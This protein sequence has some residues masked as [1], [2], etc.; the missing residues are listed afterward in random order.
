MAVGVVSLSLARKAGGERPMLELQ[1]QG[2]EV[3]AAGSKDPAVIDGRRVV[4]VAGSEEI[5]TLHAVMGTSSFSLATLAL[6]A[7]A[8]VPTEALATADLVVVEVDPA[9]PG[10]MQR[11]QRIRAGC[12]GVPIVAA[13]RGA[14]VALI[15][16]LIREGVADVVSL[17]FDREELSRVSHEALAEQR[18]PNVR[19]PHTAP[20]ISVVRSVGGCG[21]TTVATHLA[22]ELGARAAADGGAVLA[23]LDVQFGTASDY[24]GIAPRGRL[25]D[26]L[27]AESRLDEELLRSVATAAVPHL[28]V[29]AAPDA[30]M[31]LESVDAEQLLRVVAL[32]RREFGVVVLDLPSDWTNWTLAV[33]MESSAILMVVEQS[34]PSLRQA[35]RRLDLFRSVGVADCVGIVANRVEK[36]AFGTIDLGDVA[37]ALG[38]PVLASLRLEKLHIGSAQ[39]QGQLLGSIRRKSPF[40]SDIGRLADLLGNRMS[41]AA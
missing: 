18:A 10:S 13:I 32:L 31:P 26:L 14:N 28:S 3:A 7:E 21:A 37:E 25:S 8:P 19:R 29:I 4:V 1:S 6:A 11:L 35:R 36:R 33:V 5:G 12:P 22:A 16:M 30:I 23:D 15:R 39:D 9:S 27:E 40:V 24:L 2:H 20:L 34:L 41:G 38:R 17:P